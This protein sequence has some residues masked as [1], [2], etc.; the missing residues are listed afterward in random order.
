MPESAIATG[1]FLA[2][3]L[4]PTVALLEAS[5][6]AIAAVGIR[7]A[8][9]LKGRPWLNPAAAGLL[10]GALLFGM[11]P[12]WWAAVSPG[13][14]VVVVVLGAVLALRQAGRW[15]LPVVFFLTYAGFAA[16]EHFLLGGVLNPRV[17][18]LDVVDPAVLFFGLFMVTEPRTAT[19]DP[20]FQPMYD[21]VVEIL[22][23]SED[24]TT[25]PWLASAL[26][27]KGVALGQRRRYRD[28]LASYVEV[29]RRFENLDEPGLRQP[30][31][32]AL[33]NEGLALMRLGQDEEAAFAFDRVLERYAQSSDPALQ[34]LVKSAKENRER[35]PGPSW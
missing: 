8:L 11:A 1:L 14:E 31:G 27:N 32:R 2:L 26:L 24:E 30:V 5:A 9:R 7:H 6:V 10:L 29:I 12:A 15:R 33:L 28:E 35:L 34:S 16:F 4:P 19:S 13:A 23:G 22:E 18:A 21:E 17:L 25:R 20:F 3:L